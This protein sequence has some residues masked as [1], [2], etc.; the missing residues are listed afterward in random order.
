M[1]KTL[2]QIFQYPI[3]LHFNQ[4][5][6]SLAALVWGSDRG[7]P[8][9]EAEKNRRSRLC[10]GPEAEARWLRCPLARESDRGLNSSTAEQ[11]AA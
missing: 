10:G 8:V 2:H 7:G 3:L 4:F 11:S 5:I 1:E 9:G 6:Y